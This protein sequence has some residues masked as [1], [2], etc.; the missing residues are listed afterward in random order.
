MPKAIIVTGPPGAGKGTQAQFITNHIGG[1]WYDTGAKIRE[2]LARGEI[3]DKEYTKKGYAAG[4]LLDANKTLNI[5]LGD[6]KGV[7]TSHKSIVLSSSPKSVTEAFGSG[8]GGLM[9][10]LE[11]TYGKENVIVFNIH[12]PIDESIK[13]NMKREDNRRDDTPE[14]IKVRYQDQ[15]EQSVVPAIEAMETHGYQIIDIDGML[16]P[17]EVFE[18]IKRHL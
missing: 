8:Q 10:M 4:K 18:S 9:H 11:D 13:R 1:I 17:R 6:I 7:L 5:V 15:Y 16:S 3:L 2:R 12:V 14:T